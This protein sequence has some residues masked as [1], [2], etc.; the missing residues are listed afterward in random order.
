M[1][2]YKQYGIVG[3]ESLNGRPHSYL[4][5][6]IT[7]ELRALILEMC[8]KR[9][10]EMRRLQTELIPL[11]QVHLSIATLHKVFKVLSGVK[12]ISKDASAEYR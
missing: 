3:P 8:E 11:H 10:L 1:K 6:K 9:K 7:D 5:A 12:R 4:D 2:R